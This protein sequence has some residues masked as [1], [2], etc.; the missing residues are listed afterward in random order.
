MELEA[1]TETIDRLVRVDPATCADAESI[2]ALQRQLA[3]LDT[4]ASSAAASFDA[5]GEW[6]PDGEG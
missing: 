5:S 6:A 1:L 3:R 4:F 2:V